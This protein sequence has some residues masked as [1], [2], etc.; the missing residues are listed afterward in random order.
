MMI[1]IDGSM[2]EGGGQLVRTAIA[3][4]SLTG[5]DLR[6]RNVRAKRSPPGFRPQHMTGVKVVAAL[7]NAH[8]EGLKIG[9][10]DLTFKPGPKVS[11]DFSFDVG[12]A[13]SIPLILQA[14]LPVAAFAPGPLTLRIRGGTDVR[15]S[16]P[17]DYLRL[18]LLPTIAKMGYKGCLRLLRRGHYPKGGGMIEMQI[19]PISHL[20]PIRMVERG[21][22]E[23]I[24]GI[25]HCV[26]LP[27]HVAERQ[28]RSAR[29]ILTERGYEKVNIELEH[30]PPHEDPHLGPGSGVVLVARTTTGALIGADALGKRGLPAEKVGATAASKL[31]KELDS[32][33]P[34]DL[35]LA[36]MLIPY[37]AVADGTSEIKTSRLTLHTVTNIAIAERLMDVKFNVEGEVGKPGTIIVKGLGLRS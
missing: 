19:A 10:R 32:E 5:R 16:P 1:E 4:A 14:C 22:V 3:L 13:G 33:M 20:R 29:E 23:G 28:A 11:G 36:D 7:V 30:Y 27:A 6:I 8:T 37:M 15:W 26:K 34:V 24:E 31:L 35:H 17:I 21:A 9:S 12:T 2:L 25:S 18:V